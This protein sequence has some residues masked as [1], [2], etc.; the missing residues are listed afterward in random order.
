MH[1]LGGLHLLAAAALDHVPRL[2]ACMQLDL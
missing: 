1:Q 2:K